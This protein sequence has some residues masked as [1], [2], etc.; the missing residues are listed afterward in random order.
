MDFQLLDIKRC[1]VVERIDKDRRRK[2]DGYMQCAVW[3]AVCMA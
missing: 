1:A 3:R 2:E